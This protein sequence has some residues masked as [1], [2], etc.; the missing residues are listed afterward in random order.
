MNQGL[1]KLTNLLSI[2]RLVTVKLKFEQICVFHT[3]NALV[4]ITQ[5]WPYNISVAQS[6]AQIVK[7]MC[8]SRSSEE[9]E[10]KKHSIVFIP[11][12]IQEEM[13]LHAIT[14]VHGE[15]GQFLRPHS[16]TRHI[17]LLVP[18]YQPISISQSGFSNTQIQHRWE[19]LG[20][21]MDH[22]SPLNY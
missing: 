11:S 4:L 18:F 13:M 14:L 12:P 20:C 21:R 22:L 8:L 6:K 7:E 17:S 9:G 5:I 10:P 16:L 19:F 1:Q 2:T 3:L 15:S